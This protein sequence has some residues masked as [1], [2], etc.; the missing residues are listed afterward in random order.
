MVRTTLKKVMW[1]GR[2]PVFLVGLSVI[3]A[4][5]LG[6]ASRALGANGDTFII[7]N[8]LSDTVKNIATLPTKL[9]MQGTGSGPALQVTQ[10]STN[11]G[12]SGIGV[13]VPSG[14]APLRVN[15]SAGKA[16]NL[17]ADKLDGQD[18]AAF[19]PSAHS[20]DDRYFT[21]TESD[22]RFVNE[23]DHTKAA[24]DALDIDSDTLDGKDSTE[25]GQMWAVVRQNSTTDCTLLRGSGATG[26]SGNASAS[27]CKVNFSRDLTNCA[28]IA[29]LSEPGAYP[30]ADG[31]GEIW[32]FLD[33]STSIA[34]RTADSAGGKA[35]KNFHVAAFC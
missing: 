8:G 18:S 25:L 34:V 22:G 20:H 24:H 2:A 14:K 10:Q 19:A 6:V 23:T 33:T 9:T 32:A 31:T 30:G 13:T 35:A 5:V 16:T 12:A 4:L 11:T 1:V 28:F 3:V 17:N 15:S 27:F 21:E 7:G 29:G 26:T